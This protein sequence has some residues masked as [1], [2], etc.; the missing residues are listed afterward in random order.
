MPEQDKAA[1]AADLARIAKENG[2]IDFPLPEPI[3]ED[4]EL[5]IENIQEVDMILPRTHTIIRHSAEIRH[6]GNALKELLLFHK[7]KDD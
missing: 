2:N 1:L 7:G 3:P 6:K 4:L 5:T